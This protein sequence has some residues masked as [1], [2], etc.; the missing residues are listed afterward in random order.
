MN[1]V[2]TAEHLT[3]RSFK[4]KIIAVGVSLFSA[5]ALFATGFASWVISSD[6]TREQ[7]G[8]IQVGVVAD[9]SITIENVALDVTTIS[10]NPAVGDIALP[11]DT[12]DAAWTAYLA[13]NPNNTQDKGYGGRV[14]NGDTNFE[15]LKVTLTADITG[16]SETAASNN[17]SSMRIWLE[18]PDSVRE[19]AAATP[20][21]T[22]GGQTTTGKY[23]VL[24]LCAQADN[25]AGVKL[26]ENGSK[27]AMN[28][29]EG[30]DGYWTLVE[31]TDNSGNGT[32][33]YTFTYTFS[34]A[35]GTFF[36]EKNPS[37][38]YDIA[39]TDGG[40]K[41]YAGYK[42]SEEIEAFRLSMFDG[43]DADYTGASTDSFGTFKVVIEAKAAEGN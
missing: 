11:A 28:K 5:L 22:I 25:N 32:G 3:R 33:T 26:I 23:I 21:R 16:F 31:Q 20:S 43:A 17:V 35:W 6:A 24:P 42:A 1:I 12:S 7:D 19:T 38:Y 9:K 30:Q 29:D 40:L 41:S 27:V 8:N 4:R 15:S 2:K 10:F 36:G 13:Q 18:V 14:Y 39:E 37:L 34:F